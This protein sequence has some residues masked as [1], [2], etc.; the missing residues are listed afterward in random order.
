M[1]MFSCRTEIKLKM[2]RRKV[3]TWRL[4]A[5]TGEWLNRDPEILETE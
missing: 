5:I 4:Q 3:D 2:K 1:E